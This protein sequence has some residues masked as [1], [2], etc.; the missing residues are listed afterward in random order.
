MG[1]GIDLGSAVLRHQFTNQSLLC[2]I[3]LFIGPSM[4]KNSS[5]ISEAVQQVMLFCMMAEWIAASKVFKS[6]L[7][8]KPFIKCKF[9]LFSKIFK[10]G[11][12]WVQRKESLVR[13]AC[14]TSGGRKGWEIKLGKFRHISKLAKHFWMAA[15]PCLPGLQLAL[16]QQHCSTSLQSCRW[17]LLLWLLE[18]SCSRNKKRKIRANT[19]RRK[20]RKGPAIVEFVWDFADLSSRT[21][22]LKSLL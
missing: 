9:F 2:F 13:A 15:L 8:P 7:F 16:L 3:L 18:Y 6:N 11:I 4:Q 17:G 12:C 1:L 19:G 22:P 20:R 5:M 14:Q 10:L 21:S